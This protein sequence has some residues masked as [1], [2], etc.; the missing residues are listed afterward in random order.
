MAMKQ[1]LRVRVFRSQAPPLNGMLRSPLSQ[2]ALHMSPREDALKFSPPC[3]RLL[4]I[5]YP[6]ITVMSPR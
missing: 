4:V 2:Q 1:V 3:E 6:L 5:S